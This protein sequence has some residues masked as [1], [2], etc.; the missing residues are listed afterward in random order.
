VKPDPDVRAA[1]KLRANEGGTA[2]ITTTVPAKSQ[3]G[4]GRG[5]KA[6]R[7]PNTPFQRVNAQGARYYDD[8]LKDNSFE[9]RVCPVSCLL[10]HETFLKA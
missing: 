4:N 1:K 8:K 3:V 5:D 10:L 2:V 7:K 6:S 9:S